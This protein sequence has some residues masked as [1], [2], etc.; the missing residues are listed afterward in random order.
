[1]LE[2]VVKET[3]VATVQEIL[4]L[5]KDPGVTLLAS[6]IKDMFLRIDHVAVI[7]GLSPQSIYREAASDRFPRPYMITRGA[8]A[9]RLSE[10]VEWIETRKRVRST[11]SDCL[12]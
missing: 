9:W 10:V 11:T 7:T 8:R 12:G 5:D 4:G 2:S 3:V 1:M 6:C